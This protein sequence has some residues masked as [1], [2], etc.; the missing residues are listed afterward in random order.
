MPTIED[1]ASDP[2]DLE[3]S[4]ADAPPLPSSSSLDKGKGPALPADFFPGGQP[5]QGIPKALRIGFDGSLRPVAPT[6]FAGW[7]MLYPIYVDAKK[8]KGHGGRRVSSKVA[9][10]WPLAEQIAKACRMMGFDTVFEPSKTHPSDW[11]NPGRIRLNFKDDE[12]KPK[13]ASIPTK[14]ILLTRICDLL[15]P[16][17]PPTPAATDSNPHPLPPIHLRLPPNSPAISHGALESAIKGGGPLGALGGMFGGGEDEAAIEKAE[18]DRKRKAEEEE[19]KRKEMAAKMGK[20]KKV[21]VK[22][23]R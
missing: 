5:E 9:L 22:R 7:E 21:H 17:Q 3:L 1:Y 10:Q 16:H 18:E 13:I 15:R 23:R 6:D 8:S 2:D 19:K 4:L 20:L 11:E 12:G 14:R